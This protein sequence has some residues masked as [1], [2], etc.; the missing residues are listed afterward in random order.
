MAGPMARYFERNPRQAVLTPLSVANVGSEQVGQAISSFGQEVDQYAQREE[1][2]WVQKQMA[3]LDTFA[4]EKWQESVDNSTDGAD[5]FQ[6]GYLGALDSRYDEVRQEAPSGRARRAL[7]SEI[8]R[9]RGGQVNA[10]QGFATQEKYEYRKT[11]ILQD[12]D[13]MAQDI[14]RNPGVAP[15]QP[16]G[17][18]QIQPGLT[19][20]FNPRDNSYYS[21]GV[22][23]PIGGLNLPDNISAWDSKFYSPKD[24]ADSKTGGVAIAQGTVKALDWVTDQFGYG[25]LQINSGFRSG[26]TNLAVAESGPEGPHTHGKS[27][28]V[29][30]RSLPQGEKDRLYS[31][32]KAAGANAFGFGEGTMH[33][34]WRDNP[35][36][37]KGR[38]GDYEWTYGNAKPY[39]LIPV[40]SPNSRS[41]VAA[42]IPKSASGDMGNLRPFQSWEHRDNADGS[43]STE[44]TTTIQDSSGQWVNVPTL[45]RNSDGWVEL[46]EEHQQA[47]MA[48]YEAKGE[49]F[50]RFGTLPEAEAAA[51]ARSAA[52]GA[53]A[54]EAG[55]NAYNQYPYLSAVALTAR[56]E[57]G[58]GDLATGSLQIAD[59]ANGTVSVGVLG[60]NSSGL[61]PAFLKENGAAM[62]ITAKPGT[63]EFAAQWESAVRSDPEGAIGRQLQF[64]E[65]HIVGPAKSSMVAL[66]AGSVANDPRAVNFTTDLIVQYGAAG[67]RKHIAAGKGS[68]DVAGYIEAVTAS[69]KASLQQDFATALA[70]DPGSLQGLNNRI[71][72]RAAGA[73][74]GGPGGAVA[75]GN[76]PAWEGPLPQLEDM[77]DYQ[78][79][80]DRLGSMVDTMG[81][82][83]AQRREIKQQMRGQL[84]R[85]W[86]S[87]VSDI[88]PSAAM[89]VLM[90]GQYDNDLTVGDTASLMGSSQTAYKQL[91]SEIR[92]K[93]QDLVTGLK[94]EA[95]QLFADEIS[96]VTS[97]GKGLGR[98]SEAHM[99]VATEKEKSDLEF[100]QFAYTEGKE[101]SSA[102]SN[103]LPAILESLTPSGAGFAEEQRRYD[104]AAELIKNRTEMQKNDPASLALQGSADLQAQWKDAFASNDPAK[105]ASAISTIRA[106]QER[107]GVA[108]GAIRSMPQSAITTFEQLLTKSKDADEA[109]ANITQMRGMFGSASGQVIAEMEGAGL[110]KGW[111]DVSGLMD[112][113][114]MLAAKSL[115]RVVQAG[116]YGPDSALGV[117]LAMDGRAD[118]A[119]K[120]FD[121]RLRRKE[122]PGLVPTGKDEDLDMNVKQIMGDYLG[123]AV[124]Q[125]GLMFNS[126]RE[127]SLSLYAADLPF[128]ASLDGS[129]LQQSIDAV[130]G[131]ILQHN[132][133][134]STGRFIAPVPGMTQ[135]QFN[136]ALW[137][138]DDKALSGAFVGYSGSQDL[139]MM[140]NDLA[141]V[142]FVSAGDG[143]YFL[144]WPGNGLA[145][146]AD[147]SPYVLNFAQAVQGSRDRTLQETL[148][149]QV[150]TP[151]GVDGKSNGE[152]PAPAGVGIP[153]AAAPA[154]EDLTG[155][156]PIMD[157]KPMSE[158]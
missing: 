129:K 100:A 99:A 51:E 54:P 46:D 123:D 72:R 38:S 92:Q 91:E 32:F 24:F 106:A 60:L 150:G 139:P 68:K 127:A 63:P 81:G 83:P 76:V 120:I 64:H 141:D 104:F 3:D 13:N 26:A 69:T 148:N 136:D 137:N 56:N 154:P 98:I 121:G 113:G 53:G 10:A 49:A 149:T 134:G 101:I 18:L 34:E 16:Q 67:A 90:S 128:G 9:H 55:P 94:T 116:E 84:V 50:P 74:S 5:G 17:Q 126:I 122:M 20:A 125:D 140:R 41:Q 65:S 14:Y 39:S 27:L 157:I 77:P 78:V 2:F 4:G 33:V 88:N 103:D 147:G 71:D 97:T 85:S 62:G 144:N 22:A 117:R 30:V 40:V 44:I 138:M 12:A 102:N 66:G 61:L 115:T 118:V 132:A 57:T 143:L 108:P 7:D 29:Q 133:D 35:G 21:T 73:M 114:H 58:S 43:V 45:W 6:A 107:M 131:G 75:T 119:R 111:G 110:A 47:A 8:V 28:D 153:P 23:D 135:Q 87:R 31:L 158:W 95:S 1:Q 151:V 37:G 93:Q 79:R 112:A 109:F 70:A 124:G 59:E 142:Q 48:A 130:T 82:T 105:V 11:T 145:R 96:S 152:L 156:N 146:K 36:A 52:G 80:M 15:W 89:A 155:T 42:T 25:K 19:G 86:L